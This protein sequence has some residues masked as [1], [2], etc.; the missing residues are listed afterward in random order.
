MKRPVAWKQI[1][2]YHFRK[3]QE[4]IV[5]SPLSISELEEGDDGLE[6]LTET[7]RADGPRMFKPWEL[8]G[9]QANNY[10]NKKFLEMQE[11][12]RTGQTIDPDKKTTEEEEIEKFNQEDS[13]FWN[14]KHEMYSDS[15]GDLVRFK[16]KLTGWP[17]LFQ[18][19]LYG[20]GGHFTPCDTY[21]IKAEPSSKNSELIMNFGEALVEC[22]GPSEP[23][24]AGTVTQ[25]PIEYDSQFT[26]E[27]TL[28]R[29]SIRVSTSLESPLVD[30]FHCDM[31]Y[32][33]P[34]KAGRKP[35][36]GILHK[37]PC[38]KDLAT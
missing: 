38:L 17:K 28:D 33:D 2:S 11:R 13:Q 4:L 37:L 20:P 24:G 15:D 14:F 5:Q 9:C 23:R 8:R 29:S 34:L 6:A 31:A 21:P 35:R 18:G 25:P 30:R 27:L 36:E 12:L 3:N 16:N 32:H 19:N 22:I 10:W 7:T 26:W 1:K